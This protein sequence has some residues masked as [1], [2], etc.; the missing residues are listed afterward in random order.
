MKEYI[1]LF[2]EHSEYE[3]YINGEDKVLP[4]VSYC[5]DNNEVHYNPIATLAEKYLTTIAR[6]DGTI[7]FNIW[8]SMGTDM[9][10]SISYSTNNGV[11]W[12]T[13][14][15]QN[16]KE[17][18]FSINVNVNEGDTILWK[19]IARQLAY[20]EEDEYGDFVGSFFS[21]TCDFDIKG[22]I[23]SLLYG[24][25]FKGQTIIEEDGA[26]S[27]LFHDY[28]EEKLCRI[29]NAK[30]LVL[31]A[32]TLTSNCYSNMFY[33]CTTLV[34]APSILPAIILSDYCYFGMFYGCSSLEEAPELPSTT[35]A[36]WCYCD[37]FNRCISL[38]V[39]P[40]L[41]ATTLSNYCY[42]GMFS[43]CQTL[44][45]PPVLSATT[46]TTGCYANMFKDCIFLTVAPELP[47]TMLAENCY[48]YIFSG[49]YS[50]NYIKAMFTTTPNDTYTQGWV[51]NV[52]ANGTF[53]K[54][55]AAQWDVVGDNGIPSGWT[56]QTAS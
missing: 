1:K 30:D 36:E 7:S 27:N 33:N 48:E 4:N 47:A 55:S 17:E 24:D 43:D 28:N 54:N 35:L 49:C 39:A 16:D 50:L 19:G 12:T 15:N 29:V 11:A 34:T 18:H 53:I 32:T 13:E 2:D 22:N 56:I 31:P 6:E 21:S 3:A 37:M 23:M 51:E 41:P 8:S 44:R 20:F 26:F 5:I 38:E 9:I 10:I 14:M 40:E 46:L 45:T 52:A 42:N 25:N